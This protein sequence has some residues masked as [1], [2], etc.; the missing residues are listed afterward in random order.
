MPL[1]DSFC[2]SACPLQR[3]TGTR[4]ITLQPGDELVAA[5]MVED[6]G[7]VLLASSGG[8]VSHFMADK[9]TATSKTASTVKVSKAARGCQR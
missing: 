8:R 4:A 2:A 5:G 9:I 1:Y 3:K 7:S 6:G